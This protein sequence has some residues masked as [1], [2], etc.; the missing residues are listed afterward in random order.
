VGNFYRE[1]NNT[2][3]NRKPQNPYLPPEGATNVNTNGHNS[4]GYV[5][6]AIPATPKP[7]VQKNGGSWW[8]F[9]S[10]ILLFIFAFGAGMFFTIYMQNNSFKGTFIEPVQRPIL[11]M[12]GIPA[13]AHPQWLAL[14]QA[15]KQIDRYFYQKDK[16][17]HSEMIYKA[18][19][20]AI[21]TLGDRFTV[22][23]RPAVAKANSDFLAGRYVGV[24]ITPEIRNGEYIVKR[25]IKD[26]PAEK[27]GIKVGDILASVAG[28]PVEANLGNDGAIRISEKLRGEVNTRVKV[29]FRRPSDNDKVTEYELLRT[30]L[31]RPSV[32]AELLPEN[33][34]YIEMRQVFG[35]NTIAEFDAAVG[36]LA[37]KNPAGYIL[38]LRSNGGGSV[39]VAKTILGR[40]LDGGVAYYENSP[41][42]SVNMRPVDVVGST[43]LK[44]YD[45]PLVVLMDGGSASASEITIA[46]LRDRQRAT[47]IGE[48]T[49]GKGVAQ[50]VIPLVDKS[51]VRITF[52]EWF[53]PNKTSINNVGIK[54]DIEVVPTETQRKLNQDPQLDRA[55][56]QLTQK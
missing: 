5:P 6:P 33:L 55:I 46:A 49:Y 30:E 16:I 14:Q 43:E 42:N 3:D 11:E 52:E 23:N 19:E 38:D 50:Y 34:V 51:A 2:V 13:D 25:L 10:S 47:T 44:L 1:V 53:S 9:F 35:D 24:G 12:S 56:Q 18:A 4:N 21:E 31:V 39:N 36:E 26:S 20:A 27:S 40:F 8:N 54:P 22:F 45:K 28:E 37:K 29:S 17:N 15:F 7:T 32:Y 48:K 41:A